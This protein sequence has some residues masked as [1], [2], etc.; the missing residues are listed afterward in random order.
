MRG[1]TVFLQILERGTKLEYTIHHTPIFL[2][3]CMAL[4]KMEVLACWWY[5]QVDNHL[6]YNYSDV[7]TR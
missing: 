7:Y 3:A 6:P 4:Q 5:D 1:S 2:G